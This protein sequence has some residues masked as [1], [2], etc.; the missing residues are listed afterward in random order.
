MVRRIFSFLLL[1]TL[2]LFSISPML[3]GQ[4]ENVPVAHPV[5]QFL[6]RMEVKGLIERYHDAVLPISRHEVADFLVAVS[7]K[8][9][10]L[11]RA[12]RGYLTD[13]LSEFH[14]DITGN[15]G[16]FYSLID[17]G[18]PLG[19]EFSNREKFIYSYTD[20]TVNLFSNLL[21]DVDARRIRGDALGKEHSEFVQFGARL[22]GT[23]LGKLGYFVQAT[24]AQFWGSRE[25][26]LRDPEL[27]QSHALK[28]VFDAQNFDFSEGYARYD[29][30]VV[31]VQVGRERILWGNG[32]DQKMTVSEFPRVFDFIRAD[33]RYKSLK[34]I[35][36]HGWLLGRS[37][38]VTF[39]LPSDTSAMF[40]EPVIADKYIAVHRLELSF[41][42]LFD[43]GLQEMYI[44]SNRSVDLAY[45]NPFVLFESVQR[46]RGERDNGLW[47]FDIKTHFIRD[48]QFQ[49]TMLYDDIHVPYLFSKKWFDKYA[50]QAGMF[51]VDPFAIPNTSLMIE[52][53]RVEPY[54]FGHDRS[55]DNSYTSQDIVLGPYIGPNADSWFFR[56]DYLPLR[57]LS[58]SMRVTFER[59]GMNVVDPTGKL[60]KNV[61]SDPLQPHRDSDPQEK[62]F[63]DGILYKTRRLQFLGTYEFINQMW[64]DGRLDVESIENTVSGARMENA[65]V[66]MRL[67]MEF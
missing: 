7:L 10:E 16:T 35:F 27:S 50:F 1:T 29:A 2:L 33:A 40:S 32:Y 65:T 12:E 9:G 4:A 52:Y 55:R 47:A 8:K 46:S 45:L 62:Q 63:L 11:S 15:T 24:N 38:A 56:M 54:V 6:K 19:E 49:L 30:S 44:Y 57:N 64:L 42:T 14:F 39:T 61:G 59:K 41:P 5:Y 37:S 18:E 53:T 25:L 22:R 60:I 67:R 51:Y 20:S 21:F 43:I 3:F 31:S 28:T 66:E 58:L 17:S 48:V 36:M 34:Y 23:I 26:L 13:F